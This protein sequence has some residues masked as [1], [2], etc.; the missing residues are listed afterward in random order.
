MDIC[1]YINMYTYIYMYV[2]ISMYT[3]VA[4]AALTVRAAPPG[5]A[6]SHRPHGGGE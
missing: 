4:A 5:S 6:D 1:I 3:A 2:Y